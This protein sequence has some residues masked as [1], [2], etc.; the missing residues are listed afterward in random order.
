MNPLSAT[1]YMPGLVYRAN[2][3]FNLRNGVR[4]LWVKAAL[5]LPWEPV[6]TLKAD[7]YEIR[8]STD[9][10]D[11]V[12]RWGCRIMFDVTAD[13]D[14]KSSDDKAGAALWGELAYHYFPLALWHLTPALEEAFDV[15]RTRKHE[16]TKPLSMPQ[17]RHDLTRGP[18]TIRTEKD[19][20][21]Y[22]ENVERPPKAL[23][24]GFCPYPECCVYATRTLP[25]K[26]EEKEQDI[27]P[28]LERL[29]TRM[30]PVFGEQ[31]RV[32]IWPGPNLS[33]SREPP[34]DDDPDPYSHQATLRLVDHRQD[35]I[36]KLSPVEQTLISLR[37]GTDGGPR[38]SRAT[39]RHHFGNLSVT[40][41]RRLEAA[42]LERMRDIACEYAAQPYRK[43]L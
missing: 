1:D 35:C 19:G 33:E 14:A 7:S 18:W 43:G 15:P 3:P 29:L 41:A 30:P 10:V 2:R 21:Q 4:F 11:D 37:Y 9:R 32:T 6:I 31:A 25:I 8:T 17:L 34:A 5:P 39:I 16:Y 24:V 40:S 27:A 23:S 12:P 38:H 36:D 13:P 22:I 26:P 28:G 42:A 20:D